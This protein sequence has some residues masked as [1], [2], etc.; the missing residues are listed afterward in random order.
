MHSSNWPS[1]RLRHVGD[2][3]EVARVLIDILVRRALIAKGVI[4]GG[5]DCEI[6]DSAGMIQRPGRVEGTSEKE[7]NA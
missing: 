4:R 2:G 3:R 1:V 7:C 5:D 6:S